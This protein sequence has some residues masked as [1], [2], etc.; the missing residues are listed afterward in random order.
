M[1]YAEIAELLTLAKISGATHVTL[2][3]NEGVCTVPL[4]EALE[5]WE[6]IAPGDPFEIVSIHMRDPEGED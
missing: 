3:L 1:T 5:G 2:D 4:A 6:E